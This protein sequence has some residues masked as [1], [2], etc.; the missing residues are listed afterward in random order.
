ME[1]KY[2]RKNASVNLWISGYRLYTKLD[3][4]RDSRWALSLFILKVFLYQSMVEE[5][6]CLSIS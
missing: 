4:G 5:S 1:T 6:V 3:F 2:F